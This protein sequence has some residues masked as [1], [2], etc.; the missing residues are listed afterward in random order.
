MARSKA[1]IIIEEYKDRRKL[2]LK[3]DDCD[4]YLLLDNKVIGLHK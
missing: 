4:V 2:Y 3:Q 1:I